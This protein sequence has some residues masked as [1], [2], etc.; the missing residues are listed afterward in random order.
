VTAG[1]ATKPPPSP[2]TEQEA[3]TASVR[4][5]AKGRLAFRVAFVVTRD[6]NGAVTGFTAQGQTFRRVT[7][8]PAEMPAAGRRCLGAT[9]RAS[10]R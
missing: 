4:F 1:A 2:E 9:G 5:E 8:G 6:D 10:S 7:G 3:D